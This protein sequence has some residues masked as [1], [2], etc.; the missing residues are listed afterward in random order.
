[1]KK[2]KIILLS[3]LAFLFLT[4]TAWILYKTNQSQKAVV[5]KQINIKIDHGKGEIFIT[6]ED[7]Q[8]L[9]QNSAVYPVGK[10]MHTLS[11]KQAEHF[12]YRNPYIKTAHL[13]AP[14]SGEVEIRVVQR[15]PIVR[16]NNMKQQAFYIDE[17]GA[18]IPTDKE[19][20]THVLFAN[21]YIN[22]PFVNK[23]YVFDQDSNKCY[24][25]PELFMIYRL[26]TAIRNDSFFHAQIAQIYLNEEKEWEMIPSIGNHEILFG[27]LNDMESKF[28][29]LYYFYHDGIKKS[30]W[31]M[32]N[33]INLKYKN[34]VV[35][36]KR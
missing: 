32:Y 19:Y 29:R 23:A 25:Y 11:S 13:F 6:D 31:N 33:K 7:I 12:L 17:D 35:C 4:A 21:G 27:N 24:K 2:W 30:G 9:L 22:D 34:Q 26:A 36:T 8:H 3:F 16:I 28:N 10:S 5:C 15:T 1:M 14:M 20:T 18:M